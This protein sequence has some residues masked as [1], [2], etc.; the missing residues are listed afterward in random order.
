[1]PMKMRCDCKGEFKTEIKDFEG[2]QSEALVCQKCGY[3][4]LTMKQAGKLL[5]LKEMRDFFRKGRK[6]IRIGNAVG[7]TLPKEFVGKEGR[8]VQI[9]P[10]DAHTL[11]V[12]VG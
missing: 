11:R 5:K 4:T 8:P 2:L 1:M 6:T 10:L 12:R 3:V 9:T 7:I